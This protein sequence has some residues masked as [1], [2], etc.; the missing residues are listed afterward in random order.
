MKKWM[1][2]RSAFL[3]LCEARSL[4]L[5]SFATH[6]RIA[7]AQVPLCA[8]CTRTLGLF[9]PRLGSPMV[10]MSTAALPAEAKCLLPCNL[11]R[12]PGS[13]LIV[14]GYCRC[15]PDLLARSR[16]CSEYRELLSKSQCTSGDI[17]LHTLLHISD[18]YETVQNLSGWQRTRGGDYGAVDRTDRRVA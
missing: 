10:R 7:S 4:P 2:T 12:R 18:Q 13:C 1:P 11:D 17:A 6:D 9:L 15:W 5:Y 14:D 16:V 8:P 3:L